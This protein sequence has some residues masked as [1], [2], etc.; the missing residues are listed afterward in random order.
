MPIRRPAVPGW[1]GSALPETYTGTGRGAGTGAVSASIPAGSFSRTATRLGGLPASPAQT[2]AAKLPQEY[3]DLASLPGA[4]LI[5]DPSGSAVTGVSYT[6]AGGKT[7]YAVLPLTSTGFTAPGGNVQYTGVQ[8]LDPT[9]TVQAGYS[10]ADIGSGRGLTGQTVT[11]T[12]VSVYEVNPFAS[13]TT[14]ATTQKE[15]GGSGFFEPFVESA[16]GFGSTLVEA[17]PYLAIPTLGALAMGAFPAIYGGI[18]GAGAAGTGSWSAGLG[19]A[20][21][22]AGLEGAGLTGAELASTG[23]LTALEASPWAAMTPEAMATLAPSTATG[24]AAMTPEALGALAPSATSGFGGALEALQAGDI[25]GALS[26]AGGALW[27]TVKKNP[28]MA[29]GIAGSI[30]DL[31]SGPATYDFTGGAGGVAPAGKQLPVLPPLSRTLIAP[32]GDITQYGKSA[33]PEQHRFFRRGGSTGEAP[34]KF[35]GALDSL[36]PSRYMQGP[37]GG[38]D[39][40]ID[41]KVANGEYVID[42]STVSD[43]GDG[44]NEE[45]ASRL[46][47]MIR[48]IREHKRGGRIKLPPRARS[49]LDYLK[50]GR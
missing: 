40:L 26:G 31:L 21:E 6:G 3:R 38:Q 28:M 14:Y 47:M 1:G 10:T 11:P 41:A 30:A 43:L 27:E 4:K 44:S 5:Y 36:L 19:G 2:L 37:G 24:W 49:P 35:T 13:P 22:F 39:D 48:K 20:G 12:S 8:G 17:A 29:A 18:G 16:K 33:Y 15:K 46:D 7:Q 25:G 34:G 42:A 50:T 23:G 32:T 9:G 45:G